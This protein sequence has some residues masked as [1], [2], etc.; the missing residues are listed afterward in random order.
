MGGLSIPRVSFA[1]A[2]AVLLFLTAAV[3]PVAATDPD[4]II[5]GGGTAGCT[6]AARLCMGLPTARLIV[7]ERALTRN[8]SEEFVVRS[9]RLV[10]DAWGT[11]SITTGWPSAPAPGVGGRPLTLLTGST[12]G[13]SSAI[14]AAHWTEPV[15]DGAAGWGVDGL[16]VAAA[17]R[18]YARAS[19][20]V[21][22]ARP[23]G[24]LRSA[25][26]DEWLAASARA[27][28]PTVTDETGSQAKRGVWLHRLAVSRAGRRVDAC[29]AYVAPALRG[30]CAGR[31]HVRTG[32]TVTAVRLANGDGRRPR[33]TAVEVV[34]TKGGPAARP[35]TLRARVA[36]ISAAGP[37]GTPQLLLLSGIGRP[38]GLRRVGVTPRVDLPVGEGAVMR[39]MIFLTGT[40][41]G[42]PVAPVNNATLLASPAER[43]RWEAGRDSVWGKAGSMGIGRLTARRGAYT[44]AGYLSFVGPPGASDYTSVCMINP[45]SRGALALAD[46]SVFTPPNVTTGIYNDAADVDTAVACMERL[47]RVLRA[48]RPGFGMVEAA[49]G[50]DVA[51]TGDLVRATSMSG[52]HYVGGAAVGQVLD[53]DLRV[54][55]VDGLYVIDASAIP[56]MPRSAGPMSSVYMLAEHAAD[57]LIRRYGGDCRA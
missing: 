18:A 17:R 21:G 23:V 45:A 46:A 50:A 35:R 11:P 12:L 39:P 36:V 51:I 16:D 1:A 32:V 19:R 4:F 52:L 34:E 15:G 49:P 42:V 2:A 3:V 55:G 6:L 24:G 25:Y 48:F 47:R 37:Y 41:D 57:A 38:D 30:A 13:G 44:I 26:G 56:S 29:T 8:A 40:Y 9:P 31:L 22:A 20:T 53:G 54:K 5:V 27:G 10:A 33:A 14:N 43:R 7:L 28:L